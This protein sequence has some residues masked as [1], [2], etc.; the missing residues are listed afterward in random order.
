MDRLAEI[1][2]NNRKAGTNSLRPPPSFGQ[3]PPTSPV[4]L[5]IAIIAVSLLAI[6]VVPFALSVS[7]A[8]ALIIGAACLWLGWGVW[9]RW[10]N[11]S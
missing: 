6:V 3:Q 8:H 2:R 1:I 9:R 7:P 4:V 5:V 10:G 11:R